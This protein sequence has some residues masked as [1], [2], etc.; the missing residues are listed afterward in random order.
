MI[1]SASDWHCQ[2]LQAWLGVSKSPVDITE[3][4]WDQTRQARAF[5]VKSSF[6]RG[7]LAPALFKP[8]PRPSMPLQQWRPCFASR[9]WTGNQLSQVLGTILSEQMKKSEHKKGAL[10]HQYDWN[11][12]KMIGYML[13]L[14]GSVKDEKEWNAC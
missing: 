7:V 1:Q 5:I 10:Y 3:T 11:F 8:R 14:D 2:I 9:V 4:D 13:R 6:I 12:H